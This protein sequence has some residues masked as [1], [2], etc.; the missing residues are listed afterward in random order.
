MDNK[1]K[2]LQEIDN[3]WKQKDEFLFVNGRWSVKCKIYTFLFIKHEKY[4]LSE[5]EGLGISIVCGD[6][7]TLLGEVRS[8]C[9]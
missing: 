5:Y 3:N 2:Q 8:Y 6:W 4:V 9:V 7:D 1:L